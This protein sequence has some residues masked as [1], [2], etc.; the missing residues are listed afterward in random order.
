MP[1]EVMPRQKKQASRSV[2]SPAIGSRLKKSEWT[3][4]FSRGFDAPVAL[5]PTVSTRVTVASMRHSRSTPWPTIPVAPNITTF[6]I[7]NPQPPTRKP[8]AAL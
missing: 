1:T 8:L 6:I 7:C 4:S 3:I 5:R 2:S